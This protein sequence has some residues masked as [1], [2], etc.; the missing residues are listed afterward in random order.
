MLGAGLLYAWVLADALHGADGADGA[1]HRLRGLLKRCGQSY[2]HAVRSNHTLRFLE[3]RSLVQIDRATVVNGP[4]DDAWSSL[5]AGEGATVPRLYDWARLPLGWRADDGFERWLLIRRSRCD[6]H[7]LAYY[8]ACAPQKASRWPSL[9]LPQAS[10]GRSRSV[11]CGRRMT[12]AS[13]TA[14][15]A[16]GMD[17]IAI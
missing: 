2:V 11:S 16:P 4:P 9:P 3:D 7:A 17:G 15:R 8:F 12:S 13:I 14:K 6:T 1:D 5:T 10:A